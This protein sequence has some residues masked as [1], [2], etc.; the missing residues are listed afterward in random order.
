MKELHLFASVLSQR[1]RF[2]E[3]LG[4]TVF[5]DDLLNLQSARSFS[6]GL[7]GRFRSGT[8]TY[9]ALRTALDY[10]VEAIFLLT[11]GAPNDIEDWHEIVRRITRE[12]GGR[13]KI[14][15]VAIVDYRDEPGLVAFLETLAKEN[16][17][18][19]L[20]VSN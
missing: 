13:K 2:Q 7:V 18:Q 20:G 15:C 19:Y 10:E 1:T 3:S 8:P 6:N 5:F 11:D 9:L 12:N 14:Y 17:G 4:K 16:G